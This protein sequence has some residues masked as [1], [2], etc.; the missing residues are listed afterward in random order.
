ML[1][2]GCKVLYCANGPPKNPAQCNRIANRFC[3]GLN[4]SNHPQLIGLKIRLCLV[5]TVGRNPGS[6]LSDKGLTSQQLTP[7]PQMGNYRKH[8]QSLTFLVQVI[9]DRIRVLTDM[10]PLI[11]KLPSE[12]HFGQIFGKFPRRIHSDST[13]TC[14]YDDRRYHDVC[15][16]KVVIWV[17]LPGEAPHII[18]VQN[19][20]GTDFVL[21][22]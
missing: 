8:C 14:R 18:L 17:S 19:K 9:F 6:L 11:G 20:L 3:H 1:V 5:E 2:G 12:A 16:S 4:H 21:L 13:E 22:T 10:Y 15:T 7:Q